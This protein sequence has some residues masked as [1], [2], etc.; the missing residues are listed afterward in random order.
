MNKRLT[1]GNLQLQDMDTGNRKAAAENSELL[2]QLQDVEG[3]GAQTLACLSTL[4]MQLR[5]YM[6]AL[7]AL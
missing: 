3:I 1:E 6:Q 4:Y 5:D 7:S 2:R